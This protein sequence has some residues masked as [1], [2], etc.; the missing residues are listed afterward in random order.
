[1]TADTEAREAVVQT[2]RKVAEDF[3][4]CEQTNLSYTAD[5]IL[6]RLQEL[7]WEKNEWL[8]IETAPK[9]GTWI[10]SYWPTMGI[11]LYPF[12]VFWDEGWQP[13]HLASRDYSEV[14]PLFWRP[15]PAPPKSEAT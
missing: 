10:Q 1:M 2:M 15:L 12:I 9:D 4:T 11:G 5:R 13:A 3:G 8:A 14:F 7:G 6:S